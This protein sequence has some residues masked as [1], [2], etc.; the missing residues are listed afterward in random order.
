MKFASVKTILIMIAVTVLGLYALDYWKNPQLWHRGVAVAMAGSEA[1]PRLTLWINHLCC[2]G[3]QDDVRKAL[4]GAA[5]VD[6]EKATGP[7][8]LLTQAA[9]NQ[10]GAT[11]PNYG[12]A[13]VLPITDLDKLDVLAVDR[14]LR[15]KGFVAGRM[16]LSGVPHFH[17]EAALDHLCCGMCDR[18]ISERMDF[19]KAKGQGGQLKWIESVSVEHEKKTVVAYARFLETGKTDDV[20]EFLSALNYLGF[21]PHSMRIATEENMQHP[22]HTQEA[23]NA[24]GG[25]GP[26]HTH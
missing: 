16:E 24:A 7:Q 6:L 21:E 9:A 10:E 11:L 17:L 14:A 22:I 2:T 18:S 13:V 8:Q 19:L 4:A 25:Q 20:V 5:G 23:P 26:E 3:C 12:N 1:G 15:D